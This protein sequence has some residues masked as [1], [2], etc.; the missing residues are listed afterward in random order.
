MKK[1]IVILLATFL[2]SCGD[3]RVMTLVE[4]PQGWTDKNGQEF[5]EKIDLRKLQYVV[6]KKFPEAV[7]KQVTFNIMPL[8]FSPVGKDKNYKY[9]IRA[10]SDKPWE[11]AKEFEQFIAGYIK[12]LLVAPENMKPMV[13]VKI[14]SGYTV[15]TSH[16]LLKSMDMQKLRTKLSAAIPGI[17]TKPMLTKIIPVELKPNDLQFHIIVVANFDHEFEY[18]VEQHI[19]NFLKESIKTT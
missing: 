13:F 15:E 19:A 6:Y 14:P 18:E 3:A 7:N 17:E 2:F 1:I 11:K 12:N 4:L 9:E 10:L 5:I 8:V 16:N